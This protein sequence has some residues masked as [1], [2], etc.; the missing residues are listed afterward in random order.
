VCDAPRPRS[1]VGLSPG[2]LRIGAY[3]WTRV[4]GQGLGSRSDRPSPPTALY[5]DL[6]LARP[7]SRRFGP[8]GV[9]A[10]CDDESS[11]AK[12]VQ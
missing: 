5:A 1:R 6:K 9:L 11:R 2:A 3:W 4:D 12:V 10:S 8:L 7:S